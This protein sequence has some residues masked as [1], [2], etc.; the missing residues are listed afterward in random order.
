MIS[1][2]NNLVV[3]DTTAPLHHFAKNGY[4]VVGQKIFNHKVLALQEATKTKQDIHWFFN[5]REFDSLDWRKPSRIPLL[6][7]YRMRAWQLRQKYK[8]L[9]LAWSGGGDSTTALE[10]FLHNGIPLD[11][12]VIMWPRSQTQGRYRPSMDTRPE[13]MVSEWD[14][15]IQPRLEKLRRDY[16]NLKITIR[17]VL[18][19]PNTCE[20]DDD[21]I[22]ISE[23]HSYSVIQRWRELDVVIREATEK[24]DNTA[25]ILAVNPAEIAMIGKYVA[26]WFS[27]SAANTGSKSDYTLAGWPRNIEY[28]YWTPDMPEIVREQ[29]HVMTDYLNAFPECR[30]YIDRYEIGPDRSIKKTVSVDVEST[31]RFR[32]M[33]VYPTYPLQTFQVRKQEDTHYHATWFHWFHS[34]PHAAEYEAPW[35]AAISAHQNLIDPSWFKIK[36]GK[37]ISYHEFRSK[38]YI[39]GKLTDEKVITNTGFNPLY[40][41]NI[42]SGI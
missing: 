27:D 32:K 37:V 38:F 39:I 1:Q 5:N 13:N 31:R 24:H 36:D 4:Y 34:N 22:L 40:F 30:Q 6:D 19:N 17:D 33:L 15:A 10:S 26:T 29:A 23:K 9:I 8:Y 16:P 28:F 14:F 11:E 41:H 20:H 25:C 18:A 2:S 12:V 21:T 3:A 42:L 7:L 35:R